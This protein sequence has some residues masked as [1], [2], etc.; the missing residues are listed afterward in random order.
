MTLEN[1]LDFETEMPGRG[2]GYTYVAS[3]IKATV[4]TYNLHYVDIPDGTDS[5]MVSKEF[6]KTI[7]DVYTAEWLG[8]CQSVKTLSRSEIVLGSP[9]SELSVLRAHLAFELDDTGFNSFVF[10]TGYR[11]RFLKIRVTYPRE[12][13]KKAK[14][15]LERFLYDLGMFL[16]ARENS[17]NVGVN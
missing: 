8:V 4:Y 2:Y 15:T 6:E 7:N 5:S 12:S 10:L 13:E 1:I 16:N 14:K 9:S 17:Q 3:G 11:N